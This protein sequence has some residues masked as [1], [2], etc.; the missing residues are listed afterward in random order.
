MMSWTFSLK[1]W[2]CKLSSEMS[3]KSPTKLAVIVKVMVVFIRR[4]EI[5]GRF[6]WYVIHTYWL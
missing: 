1:K 6:S 4:G 3:N 5:T 2:L